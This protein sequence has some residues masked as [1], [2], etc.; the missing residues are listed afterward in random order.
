MFFVRLG[1]KGETQDYETLQIYR[2]GD[3]SNRL[4][5][6]SENSGGFETSR[7]DLKV[8]LGGCRRGTR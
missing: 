2:D 4:R 3:D 5:E 7:D 1:G 8:A 6:L